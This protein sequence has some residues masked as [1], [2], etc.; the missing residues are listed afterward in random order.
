MSV[1]A[2]N[3]LE[4]FY[5]KEE[6]EITFRDEPSAGPLQ[7]LHQSIGPTVKYFPFVHTL[8]F[9]LSWY[10][11]TSLLAA[12]SPFPVNQLLEIGEQKHLKIETGGFLISL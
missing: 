10:P 12:V 1:T 8:F 2:Q 5:V 11:E 3:A 7:E 9:R 6:L 4:H